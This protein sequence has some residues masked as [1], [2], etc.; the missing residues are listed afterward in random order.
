VTLI[1]YHRTTVRAATAVMQG[2]FR[3]GYG[4]YLTEQGHSGVWLSQEPLDCN[5]GAVGDALLEVALDCA[6]SD[7]A[8]HEWVEY[9]P[10]DV[11]MARPLTKKREWLIPAAFVNAHATVS[12]VDVDPEGGEDVAF[13]ASRGRT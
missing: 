7:I 8:E 11:A 13:L 4:T 2:G 9:D 10:D 1:L 6:E 12:L 3:D 5:E